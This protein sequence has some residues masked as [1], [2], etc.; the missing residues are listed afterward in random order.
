M[1]FHTMLQVLLVA[2]VAMLGSNVTAQSGSAPND[3]RSAVEVGG[4]WTPASSAKPGSMSG[5]AADGANVAVIVTPMPTIVPTPTP[6]A[7]RT[8]APIATATPSSSTFQLV[9]NKICPDIVVDKIDTIYSKNRAIYS[10]CVSDAEYQIYPHP[11]LHPTAQ[12]IYAMATSPP[13]IAIFMAVMHANL[14]TCDLG[15]IPLKSATETLLKIMVDVAE[16]R[17]APSED[18]F[19]QLLQ[20]RRD[21][22]LAR[23]AGV[24]FD[25]NSS[26][27]VEFATNLEKALAGN[28]VRVSSNLTLEYKLANGL[29]TRGEVSFSVLQGGGDGSG[30][31]RTAQEESGLIVGTVRPANSASI[32]RVD[33]DSS[34]SGSLENDKSGASALTSVTAWL[35]VSVAAVFVSVW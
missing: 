29:Y 2:A 19:Q 8:P 20:W 7:A 9:P 16:G 23:Q 31:D 32:G 6:T 3:I 30:N 34:G 13:C 18:R 22:N 10:E 35:M 15:G 4:A 11:E 12:Q 5:S 1:R 21:V 17:E 33:D 14:P 27:Y 25:S 28:A 26:L 24:P